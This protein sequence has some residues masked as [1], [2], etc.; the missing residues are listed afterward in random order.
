MVRGQ[1]GNLIFNDQRE[2]RPRFNVSPEG[3]CF[4]SSLHRGVRTHTDHSNLVFPGVSHPG[5]DQLNPA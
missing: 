4:Y 1:W 5:T 3:R 2:S